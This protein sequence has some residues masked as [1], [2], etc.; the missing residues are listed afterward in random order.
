MHAGQPRAKSREGSTRAPSQ[1]GTQEMYP[2]SKGWQ[3]GGGEE[4][5]P[6]RGGVETGQETGKARMVLLAEGKAWPCTVV[7][8]PEGAPERGQCWGLEGD[9]AR[10]EGREPQKVSHRSKATSVQSCERL[11]WEKHRPLN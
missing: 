9:E 5:T 2:S 6:G 10:Q 3:C 1:V 7:D 11:R 8:G 4:G